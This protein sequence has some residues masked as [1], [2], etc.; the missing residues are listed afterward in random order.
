MATLLF[1]LIKALVDLNFPFDSYFVCLL[2]ALEFP[3]YLRI[4][5]HLLDRRR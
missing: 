5:V 2:V 1:L 3:Q 4:L